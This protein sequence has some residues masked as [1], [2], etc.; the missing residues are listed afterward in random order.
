V[1]TLRRPPSALTSVR[2]SATAAGPATDS[3]VM[4]IWLLPDLMAAATSRSIV[5]LYGSTLAIWWPLIS[6]LVRQ[7][8]A[9]SRSAA[10]AAG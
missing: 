9:A 7:K 2:L 5:G 1:I 6:T 10:D 4:T 8:S 3:A